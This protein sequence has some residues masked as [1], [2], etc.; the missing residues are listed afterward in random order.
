[1]PE[2]DDAIRISRARLV[3]LRDELDR[4]ITMIDE[5]CAQRPYLL[6]QKTLCEELVGVREGVPTMRPKV[7]R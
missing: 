3:E 7:P 5:L 2:D 6:L 1:M 4:A